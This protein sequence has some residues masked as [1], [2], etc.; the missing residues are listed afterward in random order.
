M[1]KI[2][3]GGTKGA[4]VHHSVLAA[5][6]LGVHHKHVDG[7]RG[8]QTPHPTGRGRRPHQE[9]VSAPGMET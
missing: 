3:S 7:G 5:R 1:I 9:C 6:F 2:Y 8:S 4:D